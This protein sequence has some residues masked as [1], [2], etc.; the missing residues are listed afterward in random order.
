MKKIAMLLALLLL[1][2]GV[3]LAEMPAW[4]Y[5]LAPEILD[6][7]EGY[8][9]L[10]NRSVLLDADYEPAD[11]VN[12][13]A[14]K[15]VTG[16][17]RQAANDALNQMFAA[18]EEAGY[19]L[20]VKSVYRSYQTQK[21]MYSNRLAK[22]GYDDGWVAYPGSSDHQTGLGVDILNYAWTKKEGMNEKFAA[23]EE[24]K[25]MYEHCQEF[26][27][28]LRYMEDKE[29]STGINFEP[30]HFRYVGNE[31]A[32]YIMEKH[33]SLEEFTEEWQAYVADWEA[34]GGDFDALIAERARINQVTVIDTGEDG[35][36]EI[37][38]F[39]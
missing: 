30:W 9:T 24:A 21:T 12:V 14:R 25:W 32:E 16:Q 37:S 10:T 20:Y 31:A 35:E 8:I 19:K 27:F 4:E 5:P 11:L 26:G 38:F 22:V 28:V 34:R 13:T 6:N 23:E 33:L 39:Y 1:I 3:A 2:P 15:V 36:E 7:H 17:L 29:D 18:A